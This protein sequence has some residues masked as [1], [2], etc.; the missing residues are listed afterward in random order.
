MSLAVFKFVLEFAF[1]LKDIERWCKEC[2]RQSL[3]L[4][5]IVTLMLSLVM[6][7]A[8]KMVIQ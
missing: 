6:R 2:G 7:L 4:N 1:C 3:L 8:T 5:D